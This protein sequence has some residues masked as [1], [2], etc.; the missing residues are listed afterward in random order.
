MS[1]EDRILSIGG[2][3]SKITDDGTD[4]SAWVLPARGGRVGP[5]KPNI[6]G[7]QEGKERFAGR[8]LRKRLIRPGRVW[9]G[10]TQAIDHSERSFQCARYLFSPPPNPRGSSPKR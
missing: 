10:R 4:G 1:R 5:L 2:L 8:I 7:R 6:L 9:P 3:P